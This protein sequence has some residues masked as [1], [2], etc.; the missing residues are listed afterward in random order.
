MRD[1]RFM[2]RNGVEIPV[3]G[4][5]TGVVK[6]YIRKPSVFVKARVRPVLSGVKHLNFQA[7]YKVW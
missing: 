2:L 3:I 7:I 5:G 1:K 4:F 6:R